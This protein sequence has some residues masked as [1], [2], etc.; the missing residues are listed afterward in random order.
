MNST[1]QRVLQYVGADIG[2]RRGPV[3]TALDHGHISEKAEDN[4]V[5][6]V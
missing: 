5:L 1:C 3:T 2:G 6:V 4:S